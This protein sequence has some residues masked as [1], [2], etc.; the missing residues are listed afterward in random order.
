M[1]DLIVPDYTKE[2][3]LC[4]TEP[5]EWLY[6]F[7]DNKFKMAQACE[8]IKSKA[9]ACGVRSF[10][11]LWKNYLSSVATQNQL[12][13][14]NAT[15]F[16]NQEIELSTGDWIADDC[17]ITGFDRFGFEI[18]ACN[19]PI[20]PVQRL[21]NIDNETEKLK[22]AFRKRGGR[23]KS[24]I[25]DKKTL[26][27]NNSIISLAENGIA[28]NSENSKYL[29]RYLADVE[30]YNIDVI[31]ELNSVGRLGWIGE[32]GFS[33]YVENLIFDGDLSF[34]HFFASVQTK[35]VS[36]K[37]VEEVKK[38]RKN[39]LI[40]RTM[41]SASFASVLLNPL[42]ALPF[43][44][45]TWGGT[46]AG[47]TVGLMLAASVWANP[48][49]GEYIHTFNSTAVGLELSAGFVNSL[50]LC[51][52]EL[53]IM[54]N[55]SD[56]D[57]MIYQLSEG[58]GKSRGAKTGGLQQVQTWQN[59]IITT[60]EQPITSSTSNGGAVNRIIEIDCKSEKLFNDPISTIDVLKNNYG[61]AGKM[62]VDK[63]QEPNNLDYA[64]QL[65]KQIFN[66]LQCS[67]ITDKQTISA[68]ILLTADK[69]IDD[70]IFHDGITLGIENIKPFLSSKKDVSANE[71]AYEYIFDYVAI[72]KAKFDT[73]LYDE[74]SGEVWGTRDE[75]NEC[76][77]IIKSQF[78]KFMSDAGFNSTAFLSW[79]KSCNKIVANQ[80][81]NTIRKRIKGN[82]CMCICL[83]I[84]QEQIQNYDKEIDEMPF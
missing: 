72:N 49:M 9:G 57:R 22:L 61:F 71:R 15:N 64:K 79:A 13:L 7:K 66:Q 77:Y 36:E 78:D 68:S 46:E 23:W 6:Q 62:F 60:G 41:L 35:G 8:L 73:N 81:R 38:I 26:A 4:S 33:P 48:S 5:F 42:N 63:L 47:K 80:G 37:W 59:C 34:K 55:N 54:S 31:P 76:I 65:Q 28:V 27:S 51:I 83:K 52:D 25:V 44:V 2:Q 20:M 43:F 10:M 11:T 1:N 75:D 50:P 12:K 39:G 82:L 67:D 40:A 18:V 70:W 14:D 74:Y 21:V 45:H 32:H 56:F 53:Q 3:Y 58:I 17:G 84:E 19:H 69:L 30:N 16:E 24:I 29:V